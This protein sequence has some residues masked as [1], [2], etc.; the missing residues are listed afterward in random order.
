M[1]CSNDL[2][3]GQREALAVGIWVLLLRS[4][5]PSC[6][7]LFPRHWD[8]LGSW[9]SASTRLQR[10]WFLLLSGY[11]RLHIHA[12]ICTH[13]THVCTQL[14]Y[15]CIEFYFY[16]LNERM[17]TFK[18]KGLCWRDFENQHRGFLLTFGRLVAYF[19]SPVARPPLPSILNQILTH[20]LSPPT[21]TSTI[22]LTK[23]HNIFL[24]F[25]KYV[26]QRTDGVHYLKDLWIIFLGAICHK[27]DVC[28]GPYSSVW[29]HYYF[30]F[31]N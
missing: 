22:S 23:I 19:P 2:A 11:R 8:V 26:P 4:P 12:H 30:L 24:L 29:I 21:H 31:L 14:H 6:S 13:I 27:F 18:I 1:G 9:T 15:R 10:R 16:I 17:Y 3:C 20:P 5:L 7:A 25:S 28:S